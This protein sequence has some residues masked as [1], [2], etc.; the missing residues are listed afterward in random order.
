MSSDYFLYLEGLLKRRQDLRCVLLGSGESPEFTFYSPDSD[1]QTLFP[2]FSITKSIVSLIAGMAYDRL[3]DVFLSKPFV[4]ECRDYLMT[5]YDVRWELLSIHHLLSQTS[6]LKW[7]EMGRPWGPKNPLWEM[8]HQHD[9]LRFLFSRGFSSSPGKHFNYS[10][11]ISHL[12]PFLIG[13]FL[14]CD[15]TAFV[16]E[17]FLFP[18]GIDRFQWDLDPQ[19]NLC[20]GKGLSLRAQDLWAI[21]K[22]VVRKGRYSSHRII[23]NAWFDL[24]MSKQSH[25]IPFYGDYGYQWW[26]RENGIVAAIGFGGQYLFIDSFTEKVGVFLGHLNKNAFADPQKLFLR[27]LGNP[28]GQ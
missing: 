11:G 3:G 8:E 24:S 6:G 22:L 21:G 25:G 18:L 9:W 26:I 27:Y 12:I 10:S 15:P 1:I 5:N 13:R 4:R 16:A 2:L 14:K 7:R 28:P 23:S 20:G 19:G 17:D